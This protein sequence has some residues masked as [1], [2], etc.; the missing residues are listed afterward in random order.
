MTRPPESIGASAHPFDQAMAL[1]VVASAAGVTRLRG[2]TQ[3]GYQNMVGPFGGVVAAQAL[4][5]ALL[6]PDLLGEPVA[7][8]VN[9][10]AAL[11]DGE[12]E[13]EARPSRTN[14]ATQHWVITLT[15]RDA[16]GRDAT[17]VT[18]TAVTATRRATW[19]RVD[20]PRPDAPPAD[21]LPRAATTGPRPAWLARYDL[22]MCAGD[23][24]A[25][26]DG[27]ESDSVTRLW[28]RD[29]P[30]RPLDFCGLTALAD[31][32][33]PRVWRGR[34]RMTPAGT[35]SMTVYF[36]ATSA[37]LAAC[38][39]GH[40]LGQAR[41]QRFAGGFFDQIGELWTGSGALV[42][43]THQIVYFKE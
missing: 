33:Y 15:Q 28:A 8:T 22:R 14:R 43:T 1:S 40:L 5:A 37:E 24:P 7:L 34:A 19:G 12:F 41:A 25:E 20:A 30:S 26:W 36:H 21:S 4:R 38:G 17:I 29:E 31:V 35:V 3:P 39:D 6:H 27:A 16:A 42:A 32:F 11:A 18:A 9:F 13:V 10:A 23:F 2:R